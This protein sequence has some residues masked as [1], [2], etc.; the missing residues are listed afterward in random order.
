MPRLKKFANHAIRRSADL[1]ERLSGRRII[2]IGSH[3]QGAGGILSNFTRAPFILDGVRWES[4]EG[5]WQAI[6]FPEGHEK[7]KKAETLFGVKAKRI[8]SGVS[9]F[10]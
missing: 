6:K 5:F 10:F 4:F 9:K 3:K 8:S 7:R 1:I 2:N